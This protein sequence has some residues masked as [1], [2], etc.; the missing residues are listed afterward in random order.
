MNSMLH[1]L[2]E[3]ING[4]LNYVVLMKCAKNSTFPPDP[5]IGEFV[6][7]TWLS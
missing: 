4:E 7:P 6:V 1:I 3:V 2:W 5:V